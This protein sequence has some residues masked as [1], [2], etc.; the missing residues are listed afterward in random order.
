MRDSCQGLSDSCQG[1]SDSDSPWQLGLSTHLLI[2][3]HN[4]PGAWRPLHPLY[5]WGKWDI[6][7]NEPIQGHTEWA[8]DP[9]SPVPGQLLQSHAFL[10]L[11]SPFVHFLS[12]KF[13]SP[14]F[15]RGNKLFWN[16]LRPFVQR[17]APGRLIF[18]C[19]NEK[20]SSLIK[21]M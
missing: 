19:I 9:G 11:P 17:F 4:H 1:L 8:E 18:I 5:S 3:L 13:K 14:S 10:C 12:T 6:E 7:A 21:Y 2:I 15:Q 20:M 16:V